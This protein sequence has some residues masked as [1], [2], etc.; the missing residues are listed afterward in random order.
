MPS[1]LSKSL[2]QCRPLSCCEIA[3]RWQGQVLQNKGASKGNAASHPKSREQESLIWVLGPG[4][5][6]TRFVR[7]NFSIFAP[8]SSSG[9]PFLPLRGSNSVLGLS[10][11]YGNT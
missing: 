8:E 11:G 9:L 7:Q 4:S 2:S 6:A 10:G 3:Y 5:I 1:M